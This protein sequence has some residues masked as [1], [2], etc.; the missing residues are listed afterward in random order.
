MDLE[1]LGLAS[2]EAF[3]FSEDG[4]IAAAFHEVAQCTSF[5]CLKEMH[6][7]LAGRTPFNL[8][9]FMIMGWQK[10]ATTSVYRHLAR[11]P[12]IAKPFVKEPHYFTSCQFGGPACRVLGQNKERAYIRDTL[13]VE[14][15]AG[16]GLNLATMDASVDYAQYGD[17]M[18]ARLHDLF[19]WLKLVV[20]LRE[21]IGRA[22][23][24]KNMMG[25]KFNKGCAVDTL[26]QCINS[27]LRK[28]SYT[29]PLAAWLKYFP[30]EQIHIMQFE[31][32]TDKPEDAMRRMKIFL[33]LDP[34]QPPAELRNVNARGGSSGWPMQRKHYEHLVAAV[35]EDAKSLLQLFQKSGLAASD[36]WMQRW[37]AVWA[38]NLAT[39][40]EAPHSFCSVSSS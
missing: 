27:T 5:K 40:G 38:R 33:G 10:C 34:E 21:R 25:E 18:A 11:H 35:R 29:D 20:V 19:P 15:A 39:C 23:S 13:Q 8:P 12:Q 14:R 16:A 9:H 3:S 37:E 1:L 24:W 31:E 32:L 7:K 26:H 28:G 6:E 30:A 22:M 4:D 36:G 17:E 2:N